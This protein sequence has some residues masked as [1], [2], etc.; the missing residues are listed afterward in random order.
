MLGD[1]LNQIWNWPIE[2]DHIVSKTEILNNFIVIPVPKHHAM[3]EGVELK[4]HAFSVSAL[5]GGEGSDSCS[6][7]FVIYTDTINSIKSVHIT[8][9]A[10]FYSLISFSAFQ[11]VYFQEV[12]PKKFCT[13]FLLHP[14]YVSSPSQLRLTVLKYHAVRM[15]EMTDTKFWS[16]KQQEKYHS[17][18]FRLFER[19]LSC[20]E[21]SC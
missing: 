10:T 6:G 11:V 5:D 12:F 2:L 14:R 3:N 16:G 7:S 19:K 17:F 18:H 4:L 21:G 1:A 15:E 8:H 9:P 20:S 13:R